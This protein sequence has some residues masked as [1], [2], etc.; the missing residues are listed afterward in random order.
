MILVYLIEVGCIK[1]EYE[2]IECLKGDGIVCIFCEIKG[3]KGKGVIIVKGL[4]FDDVVL[5][6]FVVE[7]KKKCGC[8]GVVKDGDIEI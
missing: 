3:C 7:F 5:K 1:F 8:G 4:D 2:K 6:L